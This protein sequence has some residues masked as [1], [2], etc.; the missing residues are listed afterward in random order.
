MNDS[1]KQKSKL[2]VMVAENRLIT[3]GVYIIVRNPVYS[4]ILLMCTGAIC[5]VNNIILLVIPVICWMYITIFVVST[6]EK[7][8]TK[9]YGEEYEDYCKKVNRCIP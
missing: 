1:T 8:L 6:E 4:A 2:F 7:W 5:I 9:L 3:T